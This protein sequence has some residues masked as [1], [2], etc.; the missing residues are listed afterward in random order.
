MCVLF[1]LSLSLSLY[2][3]YARSQTQE[4]NDEDKVVKK[5]SKCSRRALK[6]NSATAL[7]CSS[8]KATLYFP[9]SSEIPH[10]HTLPPKQKERDEVPNV[11]RKRPSSQRS[12]TYFFF[13][14]I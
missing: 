11:P 6:K 12:L 10:T 1:S 2:K 13:P 7:L 4:T 3:C 9:F 8:S 14:L 5:D